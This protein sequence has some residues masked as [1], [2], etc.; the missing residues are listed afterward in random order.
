M[1]RQDP[2]IV[3]LLQKY[4]FYFSPVTNPDGYEY[5][6]RDSRVS[7]YLK[8]DG[9]NET[10]GIIILSFTRLVHGERQ[11]AGSNMDAWEQIPTETSM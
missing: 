4:D 2:R 10:V 6:F 1:Q 5:T 3:N 7:H 8:G 11:E 9:V